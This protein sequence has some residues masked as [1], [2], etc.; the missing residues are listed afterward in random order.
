MFIQIMQ[1]RTRE[2]GRLKA[3][4]ERWRGELAGGA[5][6]WLGSTGG[7][8]DDGTFVGV[9]RFE[10]PEAARRNSD[11]PEQGEWWHATEQLFDGGVQFHDCPDTET[12]G[13]GGSDDAGFV[14]IMQ[15]RITDVGRL[16][17]LNEDM[18]ETVA[19]FRPDVIGSITA[20]HG[21]GGF[22]EAVYFTSEDA[23]RAGEAKEM[24]PEM[25]D[26]FDREA[27]LVRD[28]TYLD[29]HDPWMMSPA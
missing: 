27:E 25:R 20:L 9:V 17:A 28:V 10:S 8:A 5:R 4:L 11:R 21:D 24:P 3:Q 16:R 7:V 2:P 14:Q 18:D 12:H 13:R 6:G 19:R 23:A 22:T 15:G 1:G 29:L 26:F